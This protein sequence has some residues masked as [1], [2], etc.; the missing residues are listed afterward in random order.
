M[1]RLP[2][3][4]A[5]VNEPGDECAF[6]GKRGRLD[7]RAACE[8]CVRDAFRREEFFAE[9]FNGEHDDSQEGGDA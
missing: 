2:E 1:D 4:Q 7:A 3:P 9:V 8:E 6:C 5:P